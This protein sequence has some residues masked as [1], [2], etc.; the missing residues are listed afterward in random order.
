MFVT[1]VI[2][3]FSQNRTISGRVIDR[4]GDQVPGTMVR[5][6]W[7]TEFSTLTDINGLYSCIMPDSLFTLQFSFQGMDTLEV[8]VPTD[9]TSINATLEQTEIIEWE[10]IIA[11][12]CD[13]C[14]SM[15]HRSFKMY[16]PNSI[17]N[18]GS[19]L[20]HI[21]KFNA[22]KFT[23]G[24]IEDFSY[25]NLWVDFDKKF[26]E[27]CQNYWKFIPDERYT[28]QVIDKKNKPVIDSKVELLSENGNIL[29]TARTDNTGKAELWANLSDIIK[30]VH[31]PY[32]IAVS[33][34]NKKYKINRAIEFHEGINFLKINEHN[35]E[36]KNV[37]L[38]FVMD[39][40]ES[41]SKEFE[42]L[43]NDIFDAIEIVKTEN[44]KIV[45]N[46]GCILYRDTGE[47]YVTK[48]LNFTDKFSK[49]NRFLINENAAGGGDT[50]EAVDSALSVALTKMEWSVN[51][52]ARL[53]FLVMDS[54]PHYSVEKLKR[55]HYLISLAAEKG[56]HI[57]PVT[58]NGIDRATD[59]LARSLALV[60]NGK[61]I[62]I[63]NPKEDQSR[64]QELRYY[65]YPIE[66]FNKLL[67]KIINQNS[68]YGLSKDILIKKNNCDT[69]IIKMYNI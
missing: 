63:T 17:T 20:K 24:V 18:S 50:P 4:D 16:D 36:S 12:C 45:Y 64:F 54:P 58:I 27:F 61:Y 55:L 9:K 49:L 48:A 19:T 3:G 66:Y 62:F 57:I 34:N 52:R 30:Y 42:A 67:A 26:L 37:D 2:S 28:V 60:T 59:Y 46:L 41:M 38:L 68:E 39:A 56:V 43:K 40:T 69:A 13:F 65:T 8:V 6:K 29:W 25:W 22:G 51:A 10:D 11:C 23:A 33:Y 21:N 5:A 14:P 1:S 47:L 32:S 35:R 15:L 53:L 7:K 44:P 31:E